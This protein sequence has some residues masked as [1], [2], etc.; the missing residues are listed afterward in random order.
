MPG[1][2]SI[3]L[4]ISWAGGAEHSCAARAIQTC[5]GSQPTVT[6]AACGWEAQPLTV[7]IPPTLRTEGLFPGTLLLLPGR[8][9][10]RVPACSAQGRSSDGRACDPTMD[11]RLTF[12]RNS[13]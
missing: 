3:C 9:S 6:L 12:V 1:A 10:D 2:A 8:W 5:P 4:R 11:R 7:L 13:R